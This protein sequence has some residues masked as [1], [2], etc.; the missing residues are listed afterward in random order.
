M[1]IKDTKKKY[2]KVLSYNNSK[3]VQKIIYGILKPH[4][5]ILNTNIYK[6]NK[7]FNTT[8]KRITES[9]MQI[10]TCYMNYSIKNLSQNNQNSSFYL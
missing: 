4:N 9:Q 10:Q 1:K 5:A 7:F 6:L 8:T 3:D 2:K